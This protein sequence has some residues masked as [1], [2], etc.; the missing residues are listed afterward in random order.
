MLHLIQ[1]LL[2]HGYALLFGLV[3]AEQA[4]LPIPALPALLAMGALIGRGH[5]APAPTLALAATAAVMADLLWYAL[6]VY[7]G[8]AVLGFVCRISLEPDTCVRRTSEMFGRLGMKALL[9]AKFVPGLST[10]APPLAGM[11]RVAVWRFLVW[12]LAGSLVWAGAFLGAGVAFSSEIERIAEW[13]LRLGS[14]L[15]VLLLLGLAGYIGWAGAFLG[16]GVAFSSEI[17]RIAEW[18]LRLGSWLLVLLL[19]G[20]AGYIGWKYSQR[21]RLLRSLRVAR[22]TPEELKAR[23]DAGERVAIVDLRHPVEY[24]ADS[25]RLPGAMRLEPAE[26]AGL[27]ERFPPD[28]ELVLYCS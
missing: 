19:L 26:V 3:F 1:F 15:L 21:R 2:R 27:P 22:I 10:A 23:L 9:F 17:E 11:T 6:G 18:A 4:G 16:A 7:R 20:L 24:S 8:N 12:D 25:A 5:F 28:R 14:W 13:A